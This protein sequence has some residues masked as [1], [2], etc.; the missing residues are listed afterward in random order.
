M[1][2]ATLSKISAPLVIALVGLSMVIFTFTSGQNNIFLLGALVFMIAGG[3]GIMAALNLF[4]GNLKNI[5]IVVLLVISG[6]LLALNYKSIMDPIEFQNEKD[7]RYEVVI[8]RLKDL[9]A[10]QIQYKS[11]HGEYCKTL[12]SLLYFITHD[13]VVIVKSIGSVPDTLTEQTALEMGL[14]SRDTSFEIAS[15]YIYNE[16]YM[17]DRKFPLKINELGIIPFS[18]GVIFDVNAGMITKNNIEVPVFEIRAQ[19]E[20]ILSGLDKHLIEQEKD[21]VVGS[22]SDASTAGNWGE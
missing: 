12:D 15:N 5:V 20:F 2:T 10:A 17:K 6:G 21:L 13:S 3:V 16:E 18:G 8:Q 19:K 22:M 11:S 4:K 1:N 14:I 9:R 7:K